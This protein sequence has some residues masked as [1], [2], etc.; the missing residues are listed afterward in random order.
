M[1]KREAEGYKQKLEQEP[2]KN[3]ERNGK[4]EENK[5]NNNSWFG[6]GAYRAW[7]RNTRNSRTKPMGTTFADKKRSKAYQ[8][9]R[10]FISQ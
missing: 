5:T 4:E 9:S 10:L 1:K 6:K 8:P 7:K 2:E 3:S